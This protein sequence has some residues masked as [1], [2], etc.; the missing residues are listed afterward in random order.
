MFKKGGAIGVV[1][2]IFRYPVK[3]MQG[4]ELESVYVCEHGVVG[5]RA[6][7]VKLQ[8]DEKNWKTPEKYSRL[9][10]FGAWYMKEPEPGFIPPAVVKT[11]D[12]KELSTDDPELN[13]VLSSLLGR[14]AR[15]VKHIDKPFHDSHPIHMLSTN[16]LNFLS[17]TTG[18]DFIHSRFRPSI[19]IE[20]YTG[21]EGFPEDTLVGS[22]IKVGG[23]ELYV[24]KRCRRCFF[25]TLAQPG[26]PRNPS[27]LE[28][29][30][31]LNQGTLGVNCL[32]TRPGVVRVG[33][34]IT[35]ASFQQS[36]LSS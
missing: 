36:L 27:I 4:E 29:V 5:D 24:K 30:E 25:T 28:Y 1:K 14:E 17:R 26:L 3:T 7:S 9:V 34:E 18:Q 15:V 32:V 19:L 11:P 8:G 12:G 21:E 6:Y 31:R 23:A 13:R 33:D 2:G 16:T 22:T 20:L 10:M 35:V